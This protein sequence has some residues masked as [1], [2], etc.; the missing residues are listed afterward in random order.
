ME[1]IKRW[2]IFLIILVFALTVY[3]ILPTL[4]YY[5]KPLSKPIEEK[6]AMQIAQNIVQRVDSLQDEALD[7][8]HSFS[9]NLGVKPK[10][11]Q[12]D[13]EEPTLIEVTFSKAEDAALFRRYLPKAGALIPFVPAQLSVLSDLNEEPVRVVIERKV[14]FYSKTSNPSEWFSYVP[15]EESSAPSKSYQKLTLSRFNQIAI[16]LAGNSPNSELIENLKSK[17]TEALELAQNI[18]SC[19]KL[20]GEN[21][22]ITKRYFKSFSQNNSKP[23]NCSSDL[24]SAFS[25]L[26]S[27]FETELKGK[28]TPLALKN[29]LEKDCETLKSASLIVKRN[30]ELFNSGETPYTLQTIEKEIG[31]YTSVQRLALKE[32]N[33]YVQLIE[34][35]WTKGN[36]QL[37][38]FQDVEKILSQQEFS[39]KGNIQ[40]EKINQLIINEV[41]RVSKLT[42]ETIKPI[43]N[44]YAVALQESPE[45]K[46]LLV[47]N[48]EKVAQ[49]QALNLFHVLSNNW[50]PQSPDLQKEFF[51]IWDFATYKDLDSKAS[52]FGLLVYAPAADTETPIKGFRNNSIYVVA[53]G[54]SSMFQKFQSDTS[55]EG[56]QQFLEE[57]RALQSLLMQQGFQLSYLA[58]GNAFAPGFS[59]DLIFEKP[60]Y[61]ADLLAA[62]RENFIVHGDQRV[63]TL[64]L[65]DL[66]QRIAV[67]NKIGNEIHDELVKWSDDYKAAQVDLQDPTLRFLVPPPTKNIYWNNFKLSCQEYIRGDLRKV[68]RFGMDLSGGRSILIGLKDQNNRPVTNKEDLAEGVNEL[69]QR[70]NKIG[71]SEVEIRIEGNHIA[72]DFPSSKGLSAQELIKGSS[73]LFH[74]VNEK[75]SSSASPYFETTQ[76]FLQDVWNEAVITNRKDIEGLNAIAWKQLGGSE[77]SDQIYP[78]SEVAKSLHELGFKLASPHHSESSSKFD[79]EL[80]LVAP[81]SGA[82]FTDW[83]GQTTPLVLIFKNFALEGAQIE[84]IRTSYDSKDGNVLSFNV[85]GSHTTKSG[86]KVN[87]R[88]AFY[89]WTSHF[90]KDRIFG[91]PLEKYSPGRGWRLAIVLNGRIINDPQLNQ[92]LRDNVQVTGGF[93]QHEVNKL[94][95]DL[96]AGSLSYKPEILSETNVSADLGHQERAQGITAT[97]VALLLVI[98]LMVVY[99]RFS[100][101]VASVALLFNLLIIW[102]TLQNLQATLTLSGIAGIILTLGM[103]VDANV[104][105]FERIREELKKTSHLATAIYSGYKQAFSAI[106]DSNITTILAAIILLNFDTGPI[107]GLAITLTIGITSS[108]FTA[109]FMTR[110]FF[111]RWVQRTKSTTLHMANWF[112]VQSINFLKNAR[113]VSSLFVLTLVIGSTLMVIQHKTIMGMDFKGGYSM[114]IDV[115]SKGKENMRSQV[116]SALIA[117]GAK[118]TDFQVRELNQPTALR[119][120]LSSTLEEKG[121]PFNNFPKTLELTSSTYAWQQNPR[122]SWVVEALEKQG[123]EIAPQSLNSIQKNWSEMSG[124]LSK[125]M[126]N[127]ALIGLSLAMFFILIYIS[128]RF[129]VKFALSAILCTLHDVLLTLALLAILHLFGVSVEIN[130]QVIAALMTI[131]GYSL[132]DTII[133]FDRIREERKLMKKASFAEVINHSLNVTLNRTLMTSITTFVVLLALLLMGGSKIFDFS[134]M[135]SIGIVIGTLSSLY[136]A[137]LLLLYF[138][139]KEVRETSP[140]P[141]L[142]N[143]S[144]A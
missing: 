68:I 87:S 44:G 46:S 139:G 37:I 67:E 103:A 38:L 64:E 62:T 113:W 22:S 86:Q 2:H 39:N 121:R 77:E 124:Q 142:R 141:T 32:R 63:A 101:V 97:L 3:N 74:V 5:S 80:S 76:K 50:Q 133:V 119:I 106:F 123:I 61:Y 60:D 127:N 126:R 143:G 59:K 117:A 48:L 120:H 88:E 105:V 144:R 114:N 130:M 135:M 53:K 134:L 96:K 54:L 52:K 7:W 98:A 4:I 115:L 15:I 18:L 25:R 13:P 49:E 36:I 8:I 41:A 89:S 102:A 125:S 81:Y 128:F 93:T 131:I 104:L 33:P 107:K 69:T 75:F 29:R 79:D 137:P 110:V 78:R 109:L 122:I 26:E 58:E 99:Y 95:A 111:S 12:M 17:P 90:A 94:S 140:A 31:P 40:K 132:N 85:K 118:T 51:P 100:G 30:A 112:Q 138:H 84:N 108:M 9:K 23:E 57:Y 116:Q 73:M 91:T 82:E 47:L 42:S 92:A 20:F 70:V 43:S 21:S 45:N 24:I 129:E 35:D 19:E 136:I 28:D 14:G 6:Q 34:I 27:R 10:T 1:K 72:L 83:K 16:G 56:S 71:L 66:A 55:S 11:I 65:T